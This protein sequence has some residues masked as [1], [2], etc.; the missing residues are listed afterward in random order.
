MN[1]ADNRDDLLSLA[2]LLNKRDKTEIYMPVLKGLIDI[3]E[4]NGILSQKILTEYQQI[5]F[6]GINQEKDINIEN[7]L[8]DSSNIF[9]EIKSRGVALDV[10]IR[11][12]IR[13]MS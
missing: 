4:T 2:V 1:Q 6:E 7:V 5:I 3:L 13:C 12:L 9:K 11:P 10:D 8:I